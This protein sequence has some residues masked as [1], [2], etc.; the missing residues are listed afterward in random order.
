[1]EIAS[2]SYLPAYFSAMPWNFHFKLPE[3]KSFSILL[4]SFAL[5]E[6]NNN[7]TVESCDPHQRKSSWNIHQKLDEYVYPIRFFIIKPTYSKIILNFVWEKII[8]PLS[9]SDNFKKTTSISVWLKRIAL[10]LSYIEFDLIFSLCAIFNSSGVHRR[11]YLLL[12][13]QDSNL[14]Q[15]FQPI[16][17]LGMDLS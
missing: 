17:T 15:G 12:N 7:S 2:L 5:I 11:T 1:M 3:R 14:L 4:S 8:M 13:S 9:D 6:T 16:S 10:W